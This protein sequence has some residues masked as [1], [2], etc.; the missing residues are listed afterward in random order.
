M[1]SCQ[2]VELPVDQLTADV[3]VAPFF[4]DQRPLLGPSALLDWRLDGQVTRMLL[5]HSVSGKFG[6][7]L[8]LRNN[9]KLKADWV[10]LIGGGAWRS[11]DQDR[12][13]Q[14][15]QRAVKA[16]IR[17]GAREPALCFPQRAGVSLEMLTRDI[18]DLLSLQSQRLAS[19]QISC[20]DSVPGN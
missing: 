18:G 9:G 4:E 11:L 17:A 15:V 19:C 6:E 5:G 7:Q 1:T 2:V 10:L 12:Y 13:R 8:V 14:L 3:V 16:L 20:A